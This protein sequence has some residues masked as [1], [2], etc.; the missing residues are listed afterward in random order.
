MYKIPPSENMVHV[1]PG[2]ISDVLSNSRLLCACVGQGCL[3]AQTGQW[4]WR[5]QRKGQSSPAPVSSLIS[6]VAVF[7]LD[8]GRKSARV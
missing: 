6:I 2:W 8:G 3:Y 5:G 7:C 4:R 1:K